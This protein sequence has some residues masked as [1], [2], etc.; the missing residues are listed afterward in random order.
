MLFEFMTRNS[1]KKNNTNS[2]Q[3]HIYRFVRPEISTAIDSAVDTTSSEQHTRCRQAQPWLKFTKCKSTGGII[4]TSIDL[5]SFHSH[6]ILSKQKNKIAKKLKKRYIILRSI[7]RKLWYN[8]ISCQTLSLQPIVTCDKI[9]LH[10]DKRKQTIFC[11]FFALF[12]TNLKSKDCYS[13]IKKI[14]TRFA[15]KSYMSFFISQITKFIN[16]PTNWRDIHSER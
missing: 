8:K 14:Y 12:H 2:G 16:C 6:F 15:T 13:Y 7:N 10:K 1:A 4:E 9:K 11:I 3:S 5:N